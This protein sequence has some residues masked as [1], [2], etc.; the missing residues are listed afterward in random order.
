V[1]LLDLPRLTAQLVGLERRVSRGGRDSIDHLPGGHDDVVNAV[2]GALVAAGEGPVSTPRD[3][4][5][6]EPFNAFSPEGLRAEWEAGHRIKPHRP[7]SQ[8]GHFA[9]T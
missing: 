3:P 5:D 1:E 9:V 8:G 7:P 6:D 2:A 4:K